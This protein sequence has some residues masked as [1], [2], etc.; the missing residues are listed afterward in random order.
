MNGKWEVVEKKAL[1]NEPLRREDLLSVLNSSDDEILSLVDSAR[2]VREKFFGKKVKLQYLINVKSGL[3][4]EDCRYCSQSKL[5]R[6]PIK[7]Y[8]LLS[9][10]EIKAR[11]IEGL[12]LGAAKI[13]LVASG[14]GPTP[15]EFESLSR[16]VRELKK[17]YPELDLCASL[18]HLEGKAARVLKNSGLETYNHNINTSSSF[19]QEICTTHTYADRLKTIDEAAK[20]GF[21]ICSGVLV[22]MG[23]KDEDIVEMA[24]FLREKNV[25]FI[26]VNFLIPVEKTPMA[27]HRQL[28]P[29]HCLRILALMRLANPTKEIRIAGGREVHLRG[30][31]PLGL[32]IADSI[33]I[34]DY[35]TTKGQKP[36]FD[37]EMIRDLGYAVR[38]RPDGFIDKLLDGPSALRSEVGRVLV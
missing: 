11:A 12:A 3:C 5:S 35:L 22:G 25:D 19:Y 24:L 20:A 38:D 17:D 8:S 7:K 6:A 9:T 2:K 36:L 18:G 4:A 15:R 27:G 37:L 26:P 31:Q 23:E 16:S 13:C 34:G 14:D 29:F 28:T 32:M 33:F 21:H 1:R 30:W 10:G